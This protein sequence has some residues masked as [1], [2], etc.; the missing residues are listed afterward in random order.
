MCVAKSTEWLV[1]GVFPVAYPPQ[2]RSPPGLAEL[3]NRAL[4]VVAVPNSYVIGRLSRDFD[5]GGSTITPG[6]F[7]PSAS[8]INSGNAH[9]VLLSTFAP[10]M[11]MRICC[12][13][14]VKG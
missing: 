13:A 9:Q 3:E 5:A 7:S 1:L 4:K 12:R 10:H 14:G 8:K 2:E 6:A 11:R